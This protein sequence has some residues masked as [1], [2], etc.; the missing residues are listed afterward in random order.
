MTRTTKITVF[1]LAIFC[2]V[3]ITVNLFWLKVSANTPPW[4]EATHAYI[5]NV[6]SKY[7]NSH[8]LWSLLLN[9]NILLLDARY[10]PLM[11]LVVA[12]FINLFSIKNLCSMTLAMDVI[13]LP[14]LVFSV[15]G[16]G[17][18]MC[19]EKAGFLAAFL[20]AMYPFSIAVSRH[21][22]LEFPLMSLVALTI[23]VFVLSDDLQRPIFSLFFGAT[24]GL[25]MLLKQSFTFFAIPLIVYF[26]ARVY[27]G[28]KEKAVIL[29]QVYNLCAALFVCLL[30]CGWWYF[31][32]FAYS[33]G[34]NKTLPDYCKPLNPLYHW[35]NTMLPNWRSLIQYYP[36]VLFYQISRPLFIIFIL[37]IL[38]YIKGRLKYKYLPF[39][40][41]ILAF[42]VNTF[43]FGRDPRYIVPVFSGFALVTA[44]GIFSIV[45]MRLRRFSIWFI[46]V[47]SL[48]NF[49]EMASG[50]MLTS[51]FQVPLRAATAQRDY[52]PY[53]RKEDWKMEEIMAFLKKESDKARSQQGEVVVLT[54]FNHN[55]YSFQSI[56]YY[57]EERDLKLRV[58]GLPYVNNPV[59]LLQ[60]R[61]Y[62]F[63]LYKN[64]KNVGFEVQKIKNI[65]TFIRSNPDYLSVA[66]KESLPDQSSLIVYRCRR[67][68]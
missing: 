1:L 46:V 35:P 6:F 32:S 60:S 12:I 16:I 34:V 10:P 64:N 9:K 55:V 25:G 15:F 63:V 50:Q 3:Y 8:T 56:R 52:T 45:S 57:S 58:I 7:L 48:L 20:V 29:R 47:I 26:S 62:D 21:I 33:Y 19:N 28:K 30:I 51:L 40:F 54:A 65:D 38:P 11:H 5:T 14:I 42:F 2:A 68:K 17:R 41:I 23:Y 39:F 4:D 66:Y 31:C 18:R 27:S 43:F 53:P 59:E 36:E 22:T 67:S 49:Y 24:L 44:M 13:F 37:S 61:Q